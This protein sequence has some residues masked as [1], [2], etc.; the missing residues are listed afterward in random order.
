MDCG[1]SPEHRSSQV[2][3]GLQLKEHEP[4]QDTVQVDPPVQLTLP[5]APTV[6]SQ[7]D[8]P[9]Q[10]M[11]QEAPQ[12]PLHWLLSEQSRLQLSPSHSLP[13]RS[14]AS[15]AGHVQLVPVHSGGGTSP[16]SEPTQDEVSRATTQARAFQ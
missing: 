4:V 3:S 7:V 14:Q 10:S 16:S 15:P 5:L 8:P 13:P 1:S 9:P 2:E 11:L 6:T 12:V